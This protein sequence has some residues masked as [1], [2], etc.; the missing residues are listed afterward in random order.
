MTSFPKMKD[1]FRALLASENLFTPGD[2]LLVA[3][4]GG[5]DSMALLH[6]LVSLREAYSFQ[7]TV[8]HVNHHLRS[9]SQQDEDLVVETSGQWEVPCLVAHLDPGTKN[10]GESVE[11]WARRERYAALERLRQ[12]CNA[13]WIVTAHHQKDQAE[14]VLA[15]LATGC[16]ISG[17]QGIHPRLGRIVRPFLS[18]SRKDID[19]YCKAQEIPF[20]DDP[21][22][23]LEDHPRNFIRHQVLPAW[24]EKTPSL[25]QNLGQVAQ[26]A[27]EAEAALNF[28][29]QEYL[30]EVV[31]VRKE[32]EI[33]LKMDALAKLPVLLQIRLIKHLVDEP[34]VSWR[35]HVYNSLKTFLKQATPGQIFGLPNTWR[36][37]RDRTVYI[38]RK[39]E[40]TSRP[41]Y[42]LSP[43]ET[44]DCEDFYFHWKWVETATL[45]PQDPWKETIDGTHYA[46][47]TL[48]LRQWQPGDVFQPLGMTGS[49]KISDFFTDEKV[50]RF[51]KGDQWLL[52]G[53]EEILWVCGWRISDKVKVTP[54]TKRP[55]EL[56][57]I[58]KVRSLCK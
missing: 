32:G 26:Q 57:M 1:R 45:F 9:A 21:T 7:L 56:S 44:L 35:R 22:N 28:M 8:A 55:A 47:C 13:R 33:Q 25:E 5:K 15:H 20:V 17:L 6:L 51:S 34:G 31:L 40:E 24:A 16:G 49:K 52:I 3:V 30:P 54:K 2:H 14:T 37:L 19:T 10:R 43:G 23:L 36:F 11:A 27:Q 53:G 12:Q 38:L 41:V 46:H 50:N 29:V 4:S 18:F 58:P 42:T 48:T 39:V